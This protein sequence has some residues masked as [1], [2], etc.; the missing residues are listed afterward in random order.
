[1]I[2]LLILNKLKTFK[3]AQINWKNFA[4]KGMLYCRVDLLTSVSEVENVLCFAQV[5]HTD[6]N[7]KKNGQMCYSSYDS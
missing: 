5:E 3:V 6:G 2:V 4:F 7:L 1:M